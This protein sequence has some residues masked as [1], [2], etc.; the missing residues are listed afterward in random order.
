MS[1]WLAY[2][3]NDLSEGNWQI[4]LIWAGILIG[5]AVL[6]FIPMAIASAR[7]HRHRDAILTLSLL[8][9]LLAAYSTGATV[10]RHITWSKEFHR[11]IMTGMDD[12]QSEAPPPLPWIQWGLL[13]GGYEA[14][15]VWSLVRGKAKAAPGES[16]S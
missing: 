9:A 4:A 8:W 10:N 11:R 6:A 14:L 13:A 5:C 12:P 16:S 15:V 7:R 1:L 3:E 2:A